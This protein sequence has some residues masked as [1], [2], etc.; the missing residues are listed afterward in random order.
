MRDVFLLRL[1]AEHTTLPPPHTPA[2]DI[3]KLNSKLREEL[4]S[5]LVAY[6]KITEVWYA[7]FSKEEVE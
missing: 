5:R 6:S 7:I 2:L 1:V 3:I 4:L